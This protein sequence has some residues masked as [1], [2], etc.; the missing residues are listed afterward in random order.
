MCLVPVLLLSLAPTQ[1]APWARAPLE[2][3]ERVSYDRVAALAKKMEAGEVTLARDEHLGLLPALLEALEVPVESQVAVF[4]R[5]SF[6][7]KR[8]SPERPRAIYFSD[9]VYVGYVPGSPIYELTAMDPELGPVFYSLRESTGLKRETHACLQCHAPSHNDELPAHLV[10][11]VHPDAEG[12]P[13]LRAG[14]RFVDH[15]TPYEE[16]WGGWY[17]TGAPEDMPHMGNRT[18]AEGEERLAPEPSV[19]RDMAELCKTDPYPTTTSD[20]VALLVLEHQAHVQ[21]VL[22]AAGY[23]SRRALYDRAALNEAL[24]NEPGARL[25]ST[26]TRLAAAA[27]RVV[28][29]LLMVGEPDLPGAVAERS[30]FAQSFEARGVLDDDGRSLRE[31]DLDER[32]FRYPLSYLI[33][34]PSFDGLPAELRERVWLELWLVL[35]GVRDDEAFDHLNKRDKAALYAHLSQTRDDLPSFW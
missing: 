7:A 32:L 8:I 6:Q 22:A 17:V 18:L 28:E 31:L 20:L 16:R 14:T 29:A 23:E 25:R 30:A 2:Y 35:Q 1:D 21:N 13:I 27:R 26:E 5:T 4:A 11:S 34:S 10:R 3:G 9:D 12:S 24:G 15:A 19:V 33:H